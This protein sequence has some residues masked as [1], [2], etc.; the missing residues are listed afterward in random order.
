MLYNTPRV[1]SGQR[2]LTPSVH[3]DPE[4]L[5]LPFVQKPDSP[6]SAQDVQY[7]LSNHYQHTPYDLVKDSN[8][9]SYR[10]IS[11]AAT[12]E[13][14]VLQIFDDKDIHWLALGIAAQSVYVPFFPNG[15][16]VPSMWGTGKDTYSRNS[17]YWVFKLASVLLDRNWNK[18]GLVLFETRQS[19]TAKLLEIR[20]EYD[21]KLVNATDKQKLTD[22]A[23]AKLAKTAIDGYNDLISKLVTKQTLDSSLIFKM[24]PNL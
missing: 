8:D 13:S 24:A 17:A 16:K 4:S 3:Q 22:E 11:V 5:D 10:P 7:I 23:N 1:W 6:V 12:E 2:I 19:L 14:H 20:E 18:Y 15:T 21:Q 9:T